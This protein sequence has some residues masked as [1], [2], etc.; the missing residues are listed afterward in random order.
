MGI[1][2][3]GVCVDFHNF[4]GNFT[5][6]CVT[7]IE[8]FPTTVSYGTVIRFRIHTISGPQLTVSFA[9]KGVKFLFCINMDARHVLFAA[10]LKRRLLFDS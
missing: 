6:S 10:V 4:S 9:D 2:S 1:R 7:Q 3:F 5:D 8:I